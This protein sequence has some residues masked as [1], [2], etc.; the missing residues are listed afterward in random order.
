MRTDGSLIKAPG[1][2]CRPVL[3][4][5]WRSIIRTGESVFVPIG[6]SLT[7][8]GISEP[9]TKTA[10]SSTFWLRF[11]A[12]STLGSASTVPANQLV[13]TRIATLEDIEVFTTEPTPSWVLRANCRNEEDKPS[14]QKQERQWLLP[15][16]LH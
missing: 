12:C 16:P 3:S 4:I 15:L 2:V 7:R 13:A 5:S 1:V 6:C 10:R 11:G 14:L 9:V 8:C